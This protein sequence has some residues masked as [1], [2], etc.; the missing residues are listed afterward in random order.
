MRLIDGKCKPLTQVLQSEQISGCG[1]DQLELLMHS[2]HSSAVHNPQTPHK[3]TRNPPPDPRRGAHR[4]G[5]W[6]LRLPRERGPHPG[7]PV[8]L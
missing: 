7:G 2:Q 6:L 1:H 8:R 5:R 3:P 4:R